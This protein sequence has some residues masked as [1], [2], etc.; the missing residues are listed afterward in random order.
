MWPKFWPV[1]AEWSK[2]GSIKVTVFHKSTNRTN[3]IYF[4]YGREMFQGYGWFFARKVR[5]LLGEKYV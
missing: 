3:E 5:K 4:L 2:G 1:A